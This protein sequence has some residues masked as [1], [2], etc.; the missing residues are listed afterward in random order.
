MRVFGAPSR[1]PCPA[2]GPATLPIF[3]LFALF[4]GQFLLSS[5]ILFWSVSSV[6]IILFKKIIFLQAPEDVMSE[7]LR[8]RQ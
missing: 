6:Y 2:S 8:V 1:S 7:E 5:M 4:Y 3:L